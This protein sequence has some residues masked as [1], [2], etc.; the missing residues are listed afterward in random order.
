VA[1][2]LVNTMQQV[3]GSIGTALLN[4][5]ATAAATSYLAGKQPTPL[6]LAH[7]QLHSYITAFWWSAGIFAAGAII[8][9]LLL[10]PGVH[11]NDSEGAPALHM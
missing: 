5:L 4:T 1:S 2:A 8:C 6:V 3:G 9:G 7:A 11:T 10:R